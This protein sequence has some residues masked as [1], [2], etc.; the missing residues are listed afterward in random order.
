MFLCTPWR[1]LEKW[2][3]ALLEPAPLGGMGH[4]SGRWR[5]LSLSSNLVSDARSAKR[6]LYALEKA[7]KVVCSSLGA[8]AS[9]GDGAPLWA[10]AQL[11]SPQKSRLRRATRVSMVAF[12]MPTGITRN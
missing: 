5:N 11:E 4:R 1:R 8:S 12:S 10:L 9:R 3:A 6:L 7:G 2:R